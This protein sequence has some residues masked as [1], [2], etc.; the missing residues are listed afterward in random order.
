[1]GVSRDR[2]D[3]M[4]LFKN[5]DKKISRGTNCKVVGIAGYRP[6]I[7][8]FDPKTGNPIS[9]DWNDIDETNSGPLPKKGGIS[10]LTPTKEVPGGPTI[11]LKLNEKD[12]EKEPK[13]EKK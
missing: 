2:A 6:P 10:G 7:K 4:S 1:M 8:C 3:K 13:K 5:A 12:E 11:D 9:C